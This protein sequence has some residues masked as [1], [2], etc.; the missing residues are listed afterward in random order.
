M[1]KFMIN[2]FKVMIKINH[3]KFINL[4][5]NSIQNKLTKILNKKIS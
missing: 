5:G 4:K 1:I 3:R 2:I